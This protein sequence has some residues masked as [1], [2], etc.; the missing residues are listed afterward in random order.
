ML[1]RE[2]I[3]KIMNSCQLALDNLDQD[4]LQKALGDLDFVEHHVEAAKI[5]IRE[6]LGVDGSSYMK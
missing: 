1:A 4:E 2:Y 6:E 3:E 5:L